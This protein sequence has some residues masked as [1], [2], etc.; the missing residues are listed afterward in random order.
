MGRSHHRTRH[1]PIDA[2]RRRR[3]PSG[4]RKRHRP[5]R[6]AAPEFGKAIRGASGHRL[7]AA[8]HGETPPRRPD[9]TRFDR[10]GITAK[11]PTRHAEWSWRVRGDPAGTRPGNRSGLGQDPSHHRLSTTRARRTTARL[12][13]M[14]CVAGLA[15]LVRR[16][17]RHGACQE[18]TRRSGLHPRL[19]NDAG[20][21]SVRAE[22]PG[23]STP[24]G[25][26]RADRFGIP[27]QIRRSRTLP[28][29]GRLGG[30]RR[31]RARGLHSDRGNSPGPSS[32]PTRFSFG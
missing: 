2:L 15:L 4:A 7:V 11:R 14:G 8:D 10:H 23:R 5:G 1:R 29:R 31:R 16:V 26:G 18:L 13:E 20:A 28:R 9:S 24:S 22:P 17:T 12:A 25:A 6:E 32:R 30:R 21:V 27:A 19:E 3:A